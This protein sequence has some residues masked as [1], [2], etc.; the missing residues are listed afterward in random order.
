LKAVSWVETK[1]PTMAVQWVA[2]MAVSWVETKA[3]TKAVQW[4]DCSAEKSVLA[5]ERAQMRKVRRRVHMMLAPQM[6]QMM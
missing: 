3:P 4:A 2:L 5:R 6:V 1:A